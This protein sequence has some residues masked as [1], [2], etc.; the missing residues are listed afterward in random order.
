MK[1]IVVASEVFWWLTELG[2]DSVTNLAI[3]ASGTMVAAVVLTG[4][5][6]D[7]SRIA[8]SGAAGAAPQFEPVELEVP[9]PLELLQRAVE[10]VPGAPAC[11]TLIDAELTMLVA[12]AG[13]LLLPA[14]AAPAPLTGCCWVLVVLLNALAPAAVPL[15]VAASPPAGTA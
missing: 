12:P 7:A 9:R 2:V 6:V 5:P 1:A 10:A 3:V 8:S 11:A 14:D 4:F 15:G 13:K